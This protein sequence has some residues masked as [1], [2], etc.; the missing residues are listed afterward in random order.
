MSKQ[1]GGARLAIARVLASQWFVSVLAVV[2]A[3]V[4]GAILIAMSGASGTEAD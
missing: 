2:I 4:I 3:F 1:K